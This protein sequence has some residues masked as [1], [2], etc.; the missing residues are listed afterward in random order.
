[1]WRFDA[2]NVAMETQQY[3]TFPLLQYI[4]RLRIFCGDLIVARKKNGTYLG[5]VGKCVQF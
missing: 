3:T 5:I 2:S 4:L 1:L